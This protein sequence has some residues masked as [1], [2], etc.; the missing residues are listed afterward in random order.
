[1]SNKTLLQ[2]A[3]AYEYLLSVSLREPEVLKRLREETARV[4]RGWRWGSKK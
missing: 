2:N 3:P 4:A 1:M